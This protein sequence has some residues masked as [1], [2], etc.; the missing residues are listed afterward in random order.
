MHELEIISGK[1]NLRVNIGKVVNGIYL[2]Q[3]SGEGSKSTI[4]KIVVLQE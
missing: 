1:S 3:I 4:K 2:L